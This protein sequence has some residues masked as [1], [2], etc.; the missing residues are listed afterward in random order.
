MQISAI[1]LTFRGGGGGEVGNFIADFKWFKSEKKT[2][3][4]YEHF[5]AY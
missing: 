5:F 1:V 3:I 2:Q 4:A